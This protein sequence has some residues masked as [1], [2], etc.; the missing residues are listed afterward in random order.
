MCQQ[1]FDLLK[2]QTMQTRRTEGR[3][4]RPVGLPGL[5]DSTLIRLRMA[6]L[7]GGG[8]HRVR[9]EASPL[10]RLEA[11]PWVKSK[12]KPRSPCAC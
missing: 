9:L 5:G 1:L 8:R 10:V 2:G 7:M 4:W 12:E 11:S 3:L 6:L